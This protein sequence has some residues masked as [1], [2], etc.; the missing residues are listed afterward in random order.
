[1]SQVLAQLVIYV[2]QR[3]IAWTVPWYK[4]SEENVDCDDHETKEMW[5]TKNYSGI[6]HKSVDSHSTGQKRWADSVSISSRILTKDDQ[7]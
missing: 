2:N 1:M 4:E 7:N 3:R 5:K 6:Q